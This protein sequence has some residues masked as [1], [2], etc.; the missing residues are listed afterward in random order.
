MEIVKFRDEIPLSLETQ[1]AQ[2]LPVIFSPDS[3]FILC[4]Q[5]VTNVKE[6]DVKKESFLVCEK[7][8][9]L[10]FSQASLYPHLTNVSCQ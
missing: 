9:Q 6:V 10:K 2:R 8:N 4:F 5:S 3:I 1:F 7:I